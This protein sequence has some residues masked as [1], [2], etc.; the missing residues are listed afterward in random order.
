MIEF[1]SK[2]DLLSLRKAKKGLSGAVGEGSTLKNSDNTP[3]PETHTAWVQNSSY[4]KR[5]RNQKINI[6]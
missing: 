3:R 5:L 1:R 6:S 2:G 4:E